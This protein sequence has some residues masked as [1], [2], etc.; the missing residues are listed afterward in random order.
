MIL[1]FKMREKIKNIKSQFMIGDLKMHNNQL[2][3]ESVHLC[4]G[5]R[6]ILIQRDS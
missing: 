4:D 2:P 6:A 3:R 5:G 1:L